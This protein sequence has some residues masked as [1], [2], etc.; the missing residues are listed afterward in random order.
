MEYITSRLSD[1]EL[2][3][4]DRA[5]SVRLEECKEQNGR[6]EEKK[7]SGRHGKQRIPLKQ[8]SARDTSNNRGGRS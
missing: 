4:E 8:R 3:M 6:A 5:I 1:P 2:S 7:L